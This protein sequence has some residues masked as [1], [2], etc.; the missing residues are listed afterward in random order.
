MRAQLQYLI[1][2]STC[3]NATVTLQALSFTVGAHP[4]MN[5]PSRILT[6]S[7]PTDPSM[8]YLETA[9]DGRGLGRAC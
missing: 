8:V 2:V 5:G 9:T 4:G 3:P 1:E 6:F 7:S